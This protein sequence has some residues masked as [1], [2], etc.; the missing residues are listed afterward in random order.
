VNF[1]AYN[2]IFLSAVYYAYY[3]A[4]LK[5]LNSNQLMF[6]E[7]WCLEN[8]IFVDMSKHGIS[9]KKTAFR[10]I[11][12]FDIDAEMVFFNKFYILS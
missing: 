2:F 9:V 7:T 11:L 5:L 8:K 12:L 1:K 10:L 3:A 4:I 6:F